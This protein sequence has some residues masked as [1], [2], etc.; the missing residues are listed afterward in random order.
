MTRH[1]LC[2]M[3]FKLATS[4]NGLLSNRFMP[5]LSSWGYTLRQRPQS[6]IFIKFSQGVIA[7][8]LIL[9]QSQQFF[10]VNC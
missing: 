1:K 3:L 5:A 9:K 7:K 6:V 4:R 2:L 10:I 8:G